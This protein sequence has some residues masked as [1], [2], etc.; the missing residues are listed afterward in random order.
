MYACLN[1]YIFVLQMQAVFSSYCQAM[2]PTKQNF[3][4]SPTLP[5]EIFFASSFFSFIFIVFPYHVLLDVSFFFS[6]FTLF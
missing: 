4:M 5:V 6:F 1:E 2:L 3:K